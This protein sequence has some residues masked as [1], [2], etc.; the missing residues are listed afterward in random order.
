MC[1]TQ[2][3]KNRYA[4]HFIL[5]DVGEKG[6]EK[7]KNSKV[8]IVGAGGLG[9][10][11]A[12]YLAAAGVGT[13]GILDFDNVD[14]TNLQR[15]I[16]YTEKDL[17][18]PKAEAAAERLR[19]MNSE[20]KVY[21][22]KEKLTK[23][24]SF[25]FFKDYDIIIDAC[26]NFDTRYIISDTCTALN[27]PHI[28]G[29]IFEFYGQVAV[30]GKNGPCLRCLSDPEKDKTEVI[31]SQK[32]G[33]LGAVPG[34]IGSLQAVETLKYILGIGENLQ[35]KMIFVNMLDMSFDMVEI[36]KNPNCIICGKGRTDGK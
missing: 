7:I 17:G 9:A 25:N 12:M 19:E 22:V 11:A 16:I 21:A 30:L 20:I 3:L 18:K 13:I 23:D 31:S 32:V 5:P 27:K 2:N 36:P 6:Q 29:A 35:G 24:N 28:Y 14:I 4:R 15:Q 8:L 10:P 26:D 33:V 34:V 1:E